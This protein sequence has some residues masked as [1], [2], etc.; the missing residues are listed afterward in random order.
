MIILA[1]LLH[2]KNTGTDKSSIYSSNSFDPCCYL[3]FLPVVEHMQISN[4]VISNAV[5]SNKQET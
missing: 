1:L 4:T 5:E 2:A 3:I